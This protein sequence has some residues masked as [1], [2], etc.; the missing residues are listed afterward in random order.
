MKLREGL[1]RTKDV[2]NGSYA[3]MNDYNG[4]KKWIIQI[5]VGKT[6]EEMF[7]NNQER[8]G[9]HVKS[10]GLDFKLER[11]SHSIGA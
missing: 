9:V 7:L 1:C 4:N 11:S 6:A 10:L 3:H 2:R 8:S 5:R